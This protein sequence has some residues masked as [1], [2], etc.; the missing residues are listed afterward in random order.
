MLQTLLQDSFS[1][2]LGYFELEPSPSGFVESLALKA[3]APYTQSSFFIRD[4]SS[5]LRDIE[6]KAQSDD[7][8]AAVLLPTPNNIVILHKW[9]STLEAKGFDLVPVS[10]LAERNLR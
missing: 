5:I 7:V 4:S 2:G 8:A 6:K 10:A 3:N 9:L 1:R